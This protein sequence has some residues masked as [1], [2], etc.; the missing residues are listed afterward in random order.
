M[1]KR[2]QI[3]ISSTYAD[4]K[5]ERDRVI[6]TIL[7]FDCFPA[8][9]EM[10]PAMDEEAFEYIKRIIDDSDYYLLIIG[11]R[12]GSIDKRSGKS[13]TEQEYDYAVSRGIP[14]M[15]FD[16]RDFTRLPISKAEQ[17]AKKLKK[18][19]AFKR[20]V[21]TNRLIKVW[22]NADDL[23]L[24]VASSLKRVLELQP[25]IGWVR[26]DSLA[27]DDSLNE[28]KR[29]KSEISEYKNEVKRLKS[30]VTV[31]ESALKNKRDDNQT[32]ESSHK[33]KNA[34]IKL[35][36]EQKKDLEEHNKILKEKVKYLEE[37]IKNLEEK[38]ENLDSELGKY[39]N[40]KPT[41]ENESQPQTE[42][43]T[44]KGVSF[45]MVHVESGTF[46]MGANTGDTEAYNDEKKAHEVTLSGYWISETQV[47]QELWLAVMDE[48]PSKF[49][50]DPNLPV[51]YVSFEDCKEF[52][53]RLNKLTRRE[54]RLPTEAQ[55]EFAARGGN[56]SKGYKYAGGDDIYAMAWFN[57]NSERKTHPV[58]ELAP[59]ELG[60]YDMSGN[61]HECCNDWFGNYSPSANT[62]P[63]GP[64]KGFQRVC[65]GGCC[66]DPSRHCRISFRTTIS[67]KDKTDFLGLR[68]AL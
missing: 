26:A 45:K 14:I 48:N 60:I 67:P 51:E 58:R 10:F 53:K 62:D 2:F 27:N 63:T 30:N 8:S 57:R 35:L 49:K 5:E 29:L 18:L 55:W 38:I 52:I 66:V 9:M 19:L 20:K 28:I 56:L 47:T 65:R 31:L 44:V 59:N 17:G 4:L 64:K 11:G 15:V 54:F 25:R 36:T 43:F 46:K 12:Y 6:D 33:A 24:S 7:K 68:L 32:F 41:I 39:K 13:W 40:P 50:G 23:V 37:K 22:S 34:E 16:H 3:F 61:V 1:N 21:A 42:V